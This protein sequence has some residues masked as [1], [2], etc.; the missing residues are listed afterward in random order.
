MLFALLLL[1]TACG[2]KA[3]QNLVYVQGYAETF[4]TLEKYYYSVVDTASWDE[5]HI[6]I[7]E[8]FESW[9]VTGIGGGAFANDDYILSVE[10]PKTI[11]SI[12]P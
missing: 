8:K 7:P 5:P 6:V 2:P 11:T 4:T 3:S 12:G 10:I 9:S 1:L